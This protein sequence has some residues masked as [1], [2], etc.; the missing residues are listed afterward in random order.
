[1]TPFACFPW[2]FVEAHTQA[3]DNLC[4]M[5]PTLGNDL[6]IYKGHVP[7]PFKVTK[8]SKQFL[9]IVFKSW[10]L[11]WTM[12]LATL[13]YV[14]LLCCRLTGLQVWPIFN[15]LPVLPKHILSSFSTT[16]FPNGKDL[17]ASH[18][19][20]SPFLV[21]IPKLELILNLGSKMGP[22]YTFWTLYLRKLLY[23]ILP[24]SGK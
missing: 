6:V 1:M 7:D 10:F 12:F 21:N 2:Q 24:N 4:L 8:Q 16:W 15:L 20:S 17:K 5:G 9:M 19:I 22:C 14:Q 23:W 3:M 13:E 11:C 18:C